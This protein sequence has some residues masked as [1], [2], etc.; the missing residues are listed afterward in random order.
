MFKPKPRFDQLDQY[1]VRREYGLAL[2]AITDEIKRRPESFNLLLRQAEILGLAGDREQAIYVYRQLAQ[3]YAKEGFYARAIAVT[4]KILR[5]DPA[6][7]EVTDELADLITAQQEVE[8]ASRE[9][10]ERAAV[11]AG[12]A[13]K[14]APA[15]AAQFAHPP[16]A[17]DEDVVVVDEDEAPAPPVAAPAVA[18]VPPAEPFESVSAEQ[19]AKERDAGRFFAAFPRPALDQLLSSTSVLSFAPGETIMREGEPGTAMFLIA[20]GAVDVHTHDTAGRPLQLATLGPGEFFGEVAMLTGRPRTA[21][22]VAS[23]RA[24]VVEISHED[25]ES[26]MTR[27]PE[28]REVLQKFYQQRVQSTAEAMLARLRGGGA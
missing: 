15:P 4:N 27:W 1:L 11:P 9:R 24:T 2:E 3:H 17:E 20:D 12:G 6:R 13:D 8:K 16:V 10:L 19:A 26:I 5:L 22:I 25:L 21:T 14:T 7:K 18:A 28:V 23:D